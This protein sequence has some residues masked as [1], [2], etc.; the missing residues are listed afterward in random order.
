MSLFV[1][2]DTNVG[3]LLAKL[4]QSMYPMFLN[5]ESIFFAIHCN[6]AS[7]FW[8][9]YPINLTLL[10]NYMDLRLFLTDVNQRRTNNL[11]IETLYD[12]SSFFKVKGLICNVR[13]K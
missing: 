10:K 1:R 13:N 9:T 4:F 2:V 8:F 12:Q 7:I 6:Y 5:A 3:H 11:C